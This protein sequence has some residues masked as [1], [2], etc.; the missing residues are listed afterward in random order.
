[1][2][3]LHR[4]CPIDVS[5]FPSASGWT[6]SA[7]FVGDGKASVTVVCRKETELS[8]NMAALAEARRMIDGVTE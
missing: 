2:R 6:A 5:A 4:N 7:T 1:M 3:T 8:A